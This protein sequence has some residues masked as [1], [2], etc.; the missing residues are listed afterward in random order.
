M[1][2]TE[3][4]KKEVTKKLVY[5]LAYWKVADNTNDRKTRADAMQYVF[6]YIQKALNLLNDGKGWDGLF[7]DL[8]N[9]I[10]DSIEKEDLQPLIDMIA[11]K[12]K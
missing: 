3:E 2:T 8:E 5:A 4:V 12:N 11:S 10:T 9:A 7:W 1:K 6:D